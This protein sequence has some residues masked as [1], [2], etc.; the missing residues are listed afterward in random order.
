MPPVLA[1]DIEVDNVDPLWLEHEIDIEVPLQLPSNQDEDSPPASYLED[2]NDFIKIGNQSVQT[3]TH[4]DNLN[5]IGTS[6]I[7]TQTHGYFITNINMAHYH[8]KC[9]YFLSCKG[10]SLL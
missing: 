1:T 7:Q 9:F 4:E 6:S 5:Q 2:I 10:I 8:Q 3:Q